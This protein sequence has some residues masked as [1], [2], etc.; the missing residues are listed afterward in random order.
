M[1][2]NLP[3]YKYCGWTG[4]PAAVANYCIN[5]GNYETLQNMGL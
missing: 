1:Y 2:N 4:H 5:I 3:K